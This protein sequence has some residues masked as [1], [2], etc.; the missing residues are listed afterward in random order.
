MHVT[1]RQNT[2]QRNRRIHAVLFSPLVFNS[3][4][5]FQHC[6]RIPEVMICVNKARAILKSRGLDIPLWMYGL[7]EKQDLHDETS[8]RLIS[9]L[10]NVGLYERFIRSSPQPD[11]L[12][13]SS[14]ALCVCAKIRTFERTLLDI[15]QGVKLDEH[16][17][18][19]YRRNAPRSAYFSLQYYSVCDKD[20]L[21]SLC[22]KYLITRLTSIL[23]VSDSEKAILSA[24]GMIIEDI[25][26][27]D[28]HLS[29]LWMWLILIKSRMKKPQL[30]YV[31]FC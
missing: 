13:G 10:L 12:V 11:F 26:E 25:I 8:Y 27:T 21:Q 28:S 31:S 1:N 19:I 14:S 9:F 3:G 2:K 23:P 5:I 4:D 6:I 16:I 22:K 24:N 7:I 17:V 30:P 15:A 29:W 20:F 18:K